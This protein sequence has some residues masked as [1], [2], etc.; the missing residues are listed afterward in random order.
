[1]NKLP[2][3]ISA[4]L[5]V[6][7]GLSAVL[8]N[9]LGP[10]NAELFLP[11]ATSHG[12]Y[13]IQDRCDLCHDPFMGVKESSCID[14]HQEEL[15]RANDS[16]PKQ[17]FTDPRNADRLQKIDASNCLTCHREHQPETTRAMGLTVPEDFCF[18]CHE[19]IA[20]ER[21][22]HA[23][24]PFTTCASAGC[25]NFHD[26]TALY[27]DFLRK[28]A[29]AR[30]SDSKRSLLKLDLAEWLKSNPTEAARMNIQMIETTGIPTPDISMEKDGEP[31]DA[32][33]LFSQATEA[34]QSSAHARS[35]VQCTL[36][37]GN[38]PGT[39][40][41]MASPNHN[42]CNKCHDRQVET[43]LAG[44]HGMRLAADLSPMSPALARANVHKEMTHANLSC[45]SCHDAHSVDTRYASVDACLKCH[46]DNHSNNFMASPHGLLWQSSLTDSQ[47]GATE[48]AV[49]CATCH[50]PR[51]DGGPGHPNWV[52]HNQ[53]DNLRPNEKM[54][55]S[56]CLNCHD[57]QFSLNALADTLLI[58]KNF[59]HTPTNHVSSV[60]MSLE[61][62][63]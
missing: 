10:R 29:N 1:M 43:F 18:Y 52:N 56:A 16:H 26:N 4:W 23:G 58:E 60:E 38:Q 41:W 22:S 34:W 21:P 42:D 9:K 13:Q 40:E 31:P 61:R 46:N 25:H 57:I 24:M 8:Y 32:N 53:N 36:C 33:N 51:N 5:V 27:E 39:S 62:I 35:G 59:S 44:K 19:D 2:V 15:N 14:C 48:T 30:P 6:S 3:I 50:M 7:G 11:D 63:Q 28:H 55:R 54:V 45:S 37:H 20:D 12:H 47:N 49:S 17:K